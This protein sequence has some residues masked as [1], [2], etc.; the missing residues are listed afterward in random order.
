MILWLE[1]RP[2]I[3]PENNWILRIEDT[4]ASDRLLVL[5]QVSP[6]FPHLTLPLSLPPLTRFRK[7]RM[8]KEFNM[9]L[10]I[11]HPVSHVR[12]ATYSE[13]YLTKL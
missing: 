9:C 13:L 4:S 2:V 11:V 10:F 1:A 5:V 12:S 8:H 3:K 7:I 6:F